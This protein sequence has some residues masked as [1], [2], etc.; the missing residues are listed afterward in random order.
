MTSSLPIMPDSAMQATITIEVAAD[1]PPMK[2]KA[3][4]QTVAV[5]E[6]QLQHVEV[7]IDLRPEQQ[8]A[9]RR[10]RHDEQVDQQQ[11]DREQPAR[12]PQARRMAVL[13][14]RRHGTGAAGRGRPWPSSSVVTTQVSGEPSR[15]D[16]LGDRRRSREPA[17]RG[18][19]VRRTA[20]TARTARRVSS[21]SSLTTD[22]KAIASIMPRC[23]SEACTLRTPNRMVKTAISAA[24]ISEVSV[25]TDA[26]ASRRATASARRWS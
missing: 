5:A 10:D 19:P 20:R 9:G 18:R 16:A 1:S 8:Q 22:S 11:I 3:D 4:S 14:H 21:A 12:G 13:D 7:G 26:G 2:T 23:C 25:W 17:P 6:R 15:V 24:T